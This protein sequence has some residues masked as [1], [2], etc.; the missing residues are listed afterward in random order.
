[1]YHRL[2]GEYICLLAEASGGAWIEHK[3]G[4]SSGV[5]FLGYCLGLTF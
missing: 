2:Y 5:F 3:H 1:V 4:R